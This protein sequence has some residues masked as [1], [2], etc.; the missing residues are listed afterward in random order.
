MR[1]E[2]NRV[3]GFTRTID[4]GIVPLLRKQQTFPDEMMF[5]TSG[6]LEAIP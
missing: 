1:R 6:G 3:A 5:V 4:Q 2:I